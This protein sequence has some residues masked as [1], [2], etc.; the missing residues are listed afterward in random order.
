MSGRWGVSALSKGNANVAYNEEI[1]VDKETGEFLI[2]TKSTG[3]IISYNFL[4]RLDNHKH[5]VISTAHNMRIYGKIYLVN[6]DRD[7]P[8]ICSDGEILNLDDNTDIDSGL[9]TSDPSYI[10]TD[11][12]KIPY[13]FTKFMLSIDL[14][15][16]VIQEGVYTIKEINPTI[17]I[18][19]N[20]RGYNSVT[21]LYE[22]SSK[23]VSLLLTDL[24]KHIFTPA[25]FFIV[26]G[27]IINWDT[28]YIS[29]IN[30]SK[31]N[32]DVVDTVYRD[33]LHSI[34]LVVE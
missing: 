23:T 12:I 29:N 10:T 26:N 7:Y 8:I 34:I 13:H 28:F 17:N 9:N 14:S 33:I 16:L 25:M 30:I 22:T 19:Y 11:F 15:S 3:D 24:N 1:L 4:N 31:A 27:S 21:G 18:T 32:Y 20:L 2:K 6:F 5:K